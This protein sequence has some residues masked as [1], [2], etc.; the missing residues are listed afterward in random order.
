[1]LKYPRGNENSTSLHKS[2]QRYFQ[3]YRPHTFYLSNALCRPMHIVPGGVE[4]R[5]KSWDYN[6]YHSWY[7]TGTVRSFISWESNFLL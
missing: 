3:L 4:K 1:M 5:E 6:F 2:I 7:D